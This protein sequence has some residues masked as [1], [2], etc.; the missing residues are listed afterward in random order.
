VV[1]L[2]GGIGPDLVHYV[3]K[4][5]AAVLGH[6]GQAVLRARVR[7]MRYRDP[8]RSEP[9]VARA[10]VDLDGTRSTCVLPPRALARPSTCSWNAS[11]TVW[12]GCAGRA[13]GSGW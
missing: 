9:V 4:K 5:M 8:A 12:N 1:E 10:D 13:A 3:R 2:Q 6:T 11:T 7:V